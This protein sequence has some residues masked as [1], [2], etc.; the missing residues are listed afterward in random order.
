MKKLIIAILLG[1]TLMSCSAGIGASVGKGG[2]REEGV[3]WE[4]SSGQF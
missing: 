4:R 1:L 2:F 3:Q